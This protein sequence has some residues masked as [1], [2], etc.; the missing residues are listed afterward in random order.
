MS[1]ETRDRFDECV[2]AEHRDTSS[3]VQEFGWLTT[4][5]A[6]VSADGRDGAHAG[7]TYTRQNQENYHL[8]ARQNLAPGR[9]TLI[10][11]SAIWM[12]V[13]IV[14]VRITSVRPGVTAED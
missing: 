6:T 13:A 7:K 2:E 9:R 11:A 3:P 4:A 10:G 12:G 8:G 5:S 14:E 1:Y